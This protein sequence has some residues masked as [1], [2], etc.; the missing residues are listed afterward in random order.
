M[1]S[2]KRSVKVSLP[3]EQIVM[4]GKLMELGE[5]EH[6]ATSQMSFA[7]VSAKDNVKMSAGVQESVTK[8]VKLSLP[9]I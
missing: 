9:F 5:R 1:D 3:N 7:T 6:P 2:R 4:D 8:G